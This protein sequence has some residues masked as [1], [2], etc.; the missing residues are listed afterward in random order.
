MTSSHFHAVI[1]IDHHQARV[2]HFNA[3]EEDHHKVHPHNPSVHIHHKANTIGAGHEAMEPA[4]MNDVAHAVSKAGEI[5]LIGPGSAKSEFAS[6]LDSHNPGLRAKILGVEAVDHPSDGEI[7][8]YARKFF[9][10]V[11]AMLPR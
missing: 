3:S 4:F 11:D 10:P 6:Y 7:V 8:A 5:L 9:K 2:F 1:W